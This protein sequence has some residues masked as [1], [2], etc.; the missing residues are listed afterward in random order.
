MVVVATGNLLR[1][2]VV[3]TESVVALMLDVDVTELKQMTGLLLFTDVVDSLMATEAKVERSEVKLSTSSEDE[4][5][6]R[7]GGST[8]GSNVRT[9]GDDERVNGVTGLVGTLAPSCKLSSLSELFVVSFPS[10]RFMSSMRPDS[11]LLWAWV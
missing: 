1:T 4:F 5:G 3:F 2:V 11:L 10:S 9:V 6:V 7:V 8:D